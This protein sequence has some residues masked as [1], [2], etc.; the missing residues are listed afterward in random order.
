MNERFAL[1]RHITVELT[2]CD[3]IRIADPE[4][5]E[6]AL[7]GAA[8]HAGAHIIESSFH[9]FEPQGVSGFVIIS[10]SHFSIHTWPEY[11]YAALDVFT[12]GETIAPYAGVDFLKKELCAREAIVSADMWRGTVFK[13]ENDGTIQSSMDNSRQSNDLHTLFLA[14]NAAAISSS[15]D[16]AGC[17]IR[18]GTLR[19]A[20][21][22][23]AELIGMDKS[24]EA[25]VEKRFDNGDQT[26]A[27]ETGTAS[28]RLRSDKA[29]HAVFVELFSKEYTD[30]RLCAEKALECLGAKSYKIHPALRIV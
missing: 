23:L 17:R 20:A 9:R 1:G 6:K 29:K 4:A 19:K 28:I 13:R 30:P 22:A 8:E 15:L 18:E 24:A 11:N 3:P 12:C 26:C 27:I 14:G 10:E 7:L 5:V 21:E 2:G 16:F 25:P